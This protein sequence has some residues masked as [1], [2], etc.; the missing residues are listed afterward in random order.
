MNRSAAQ[1]AERRR[2]LVA[3]AAAERDA[4]A[5]A[6]EPW[7]GRLALADRGVAAV[8]YVARRPALIAGAVAAL[9]VLRPKRAT[10]WLLRGLR[11]WQM[12][13]RLR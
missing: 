8:R 1:L 11:V 12:G 4:L 2:Q 10:T 13:R 9:A 3:R 7:R 6:L 5:H